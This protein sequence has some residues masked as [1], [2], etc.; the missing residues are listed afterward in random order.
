MSTETLQLLNYR[1]FG[2]GHMGLAS[3]LAALTLLFVTGFARYPSRG[4]GL[5][6]FL[7]LVTRMVPRVALVVPYFLMMIRSGSGR[8]RVSGTAGESVEVRSV[9]I[10][11]DG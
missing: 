1:I 6:R 7:I 9:P 5:V 8:R 10:S 3:A 11:K 4:A 2:L